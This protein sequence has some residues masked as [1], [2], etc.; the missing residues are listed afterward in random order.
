MLDAPFGRAEG[1]FGGPGVGREDRDGLLGRERESAIVRG[2]RLLDGG[3][4]DRQ[5]LGRSLVGAREIRLREGELR[6][7]APFRRCEAIRLREMLGR[8]L[9]LVRARSELA[10]AAPERGAHD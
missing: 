9:R 6:T 3:A 4:P 5:S 2:E 7:L 8:A 10:G 1:L